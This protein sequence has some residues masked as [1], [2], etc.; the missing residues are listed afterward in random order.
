MFRPQRVGFP[1]STRQLGSW[2]A[3]MSQ[4]TLFRPLILQL[5]H[6]LDIRL[7]NQGFKNLA[8]VVP[9]YPIAT[10]LPPRCLRGPTCAVK[11]IKITLWISISAQRTRV[12]APATIF[13]LSWFSSNKTE[14]LAK[15]QGNS[16]AV[17]APSG[18]LA[19]PATGTSIQVWSWLIRQCGLAT[20]TCPTP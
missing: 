9:I 13:V 16:E 12:E 4:W 18:Y 14:K 19:L 15:C 2:P 17:D 20:K 10:S 6:T 8:S 1:L 7:I 3:W 11:N 5:G